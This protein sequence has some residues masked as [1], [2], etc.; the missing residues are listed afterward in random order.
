MKAK[1]Y[2]R[3]NLVRTPVGENL[4]LVYPCAEHAAQI[5]PGEDVALLDSCQAFKTL[6]QHACHWL[7]TRNKEK[8]YVEDLFLAKVASSAPRLIGKIVRSLR[9]RIN[10]NNGSERSQIEAVEQRLLQLV[11]LGLFVPEE[12]FLKRCPNRAPFKSN[13]SEP[14]IA[15][16]GVLTCDRT[17]SLRAC[18]ESYIEN[19]RGHSHCAVFGIMDDSTDLSTQNNN[20]QMLSHLQAQYGVEVSYA[21]SQ[22]KTDFA[23]ALIKKGNLPAEVVSFALSDI[24]G[25]GYTG[26]A[27]GNALLLHSAGEMLFSTDDDMLCRV[28]SAPECKSD[29]MFESGPDFLQ[30]WFFPDRES[31]FLSVAGS[32][33]DMLSVHQQLLGKALSEF[34]STEEPNKSLTL[35][36][37]SD[38]LFQG[39]LSGEGRVLVTFPGL[40]GD[41]GTQTPVGHLFLNGD[42]RK[43]LLQSDAAYH[44]ACTSREVLRIVDRPTITDWPWF[45][46]GAMGLDNRELL[47]PFMPVM[48]NYDGVFAAVLL[49]CFKH[50][51]FG[52]LPYTVLHAPPEHRMFRAGEILGAFSQLR[53]C[54]VMIACINSFQ[55]SPSVLP[56]SR[57]LRMLGQYLTEL[58][59]LP[60]QAFE[61]NLRLWIWQMQSSRISQME[62][63]L[64]F[65]RES[66]KNWAADVSRVSEHLRKALTKKDYLVP[67]DL[68][69]A[70][71][72][73]QRKVLTQRLVFRYGQLLYWWPDIVAAA[74]ELRDQGQ[75]LGAAISKFFNESGNRN[76][77]NHYRTSDSHHLT[78][79]E[80]T[81]NQKLIAGSFAQPVWAETEF[82]FHNRPSRSPKNEGIASECA[83]FCDYP[84]NLK[85][86]SFGGFEIAYRKG[87][88]DEAV[89]A[90]SFDHDIFFNNVPEYQPASNHVVVDIGAH[91]GT[92]SLLAS[93]KLPLGKVYAVEACEDTFN[94]LRVNVALN[95]AANISVHRLAIT[96]KR[97]DATLYYDAGNWGHSVVKELSGRSEQVPACSLSDFIEDNGIQRC[98]FAKLNCEGAEFPILLNTPPK[99]LRKFNILLVLY[100]ND[101]WEQNTPQD[102]L[103]HLTAS[104]FK[105]V[106]RNRTEM[107]G[108]IVALN[109]NSGATPNRTM[110]C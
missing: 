63:Q 110:L 51:F 93:R 94:V 57:N 47:P 100:H 109:V 91:I 29:L 79:T 34:I 59:S 45:M 88:A 18:L 90:H 58:S 30:L 21:D 38:A 60:R 81:L 53:L 74:K 77:P 62:K 92:F 49:K 105:C 65:H 48:R 28:A 68:G 6:Q 37:I 96:D 101:L 50:G 72:L 103:A 36:Q 107:R 64:K 71:N 16:I 42:S 95:R 89:I 3:N 78:S 26:G 10:T 66:P 75:T 15:S 106:V 87:T 108:W 27:N 14:K 31:A 55:P 97:C 61:E 99:I 8:E 5:L 9:A 23:K 1:R 40:L 39:L 86:G 46:S 73:E 85:L 35:G 17:E 76:A 83:S 67:Q 4:E 104:G 82:S 32:E 12:D 33:R 11:E 24:E 7:L 70:I 22:Q 19:R 54:D 69:K 98:D 80:Q 44:I 2:R 25:C 13:S 102:L 41:S 56:A 84:S 20:R 52:H 43:R